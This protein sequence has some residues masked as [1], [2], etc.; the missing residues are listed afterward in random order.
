VE[1]DSGN[2]PL[3]AI[4]VL[5]IIVGLPL[6]WI[7]L[8]TSFAGVFIVIVGI[9]WLTK[10][11]FPIRNFGH[12]VH[13]TTDDPWPVVYE[14]NLDL[15]FAHTLDARLR[16]EDI[17]TVVENENLFN[18]GINWEFGLSVPLRVR[19]PREHEEKA[20]E[21]ASQLSENRSLNPSDTSR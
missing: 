21:I 1:D 9:T 17:P 10:G 14:T 20:H 6:I 13:D 18:S 3:T 16:A 2:H 8:G 4:G 12:E 15:A 7:V 19:V 11:R 5:L